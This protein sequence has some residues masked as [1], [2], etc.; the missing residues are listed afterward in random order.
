MFKFEVG[1]R[2]PGPI[3]DIEGSVMDIWPDGLILILQVPNLTPEELTAFKQSF[4]T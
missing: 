4:T 2:F 1:E 3:P